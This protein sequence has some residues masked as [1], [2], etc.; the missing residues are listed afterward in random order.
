MKYKFYKFYNKFIELNPCRYFLNIRGVFIDFRIR[1]AHNVKTSRGIFFA[2][3]FRK[4]KT[5]KN[6]I[7]KY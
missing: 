4:I 2:N 5:R 1:K 7:K 6:P 3:K